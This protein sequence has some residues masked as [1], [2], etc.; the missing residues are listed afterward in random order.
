MFPRSPRCQIRPSLSEI[1]RLQLSLQKLRETQDLL[2][3]HLQTSEEEDAE[4]TKA[5]EEND[6][7]M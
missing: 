2:R 3:E 5:V 6:V 7:V 4:I 1:A